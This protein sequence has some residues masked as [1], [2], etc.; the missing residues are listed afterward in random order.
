MGGL[1]GRNEYDANVTWVKYGNAQQRLQCTATVRGMLMRLCC[2]GWNMHATN[3]KLCQH[4]A[5]LSQE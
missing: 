1:Q 3:V 5:Q 2:Y 4:T